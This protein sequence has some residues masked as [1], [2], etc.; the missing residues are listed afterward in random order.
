[1][2]LQEKTQKVERKKWSPAVKPSQPAQAA[3]EV[4]PTEATSLSPE[5]TEEA[6]GSM[7]SPAPTSEA[8]NPIAPERKKWQPKPKTET[9]S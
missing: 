9:K 4:S 8:A 5:P 1:V 2:P 6:S 7:S 3:G